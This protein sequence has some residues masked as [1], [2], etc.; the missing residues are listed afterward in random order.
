MSINTSPRFLFTRLAG[1]GVCLS[2]Y[3]A[4]F[5][6]GTSVAPLPGDAAVAVG[7]ERTDPDQPGVRGDDQTASLKRR[8]A[9]SSPNPDA[10]WTGMRV[11]RITE[12]LVVDLDQVGPFSLVGDGRTRIIMAGPGPALRIVGTHEGTA[13]PSSMKPNI[14]EKQR[15]P[16]IDNVEIVGEH[17]E[18]CGIELTG[19]VQATITR[20]NIRD[21][22]HAIHLTRRNR[23]VLIADCHLYHN[24]G[25]GLLLDDVDLHQINVTGCHISYNDG[26]GVVSRKGNVRNL[27]I[28]GCD[29]ESNHGADSEPTANV[30]IDCRDSVNGTAEV[31]ITGCT[32]QHN[33]ESP[34]SANIRIIGR[35]QDRP[36]ATTPEGTLNREGN[37][38][39]TGNVLSDVMTNVHLKDC[40]GVTLQGNT[41]WMGFEHNLLVEDC[42]SIVLGPNNLDRN[43]RYAY[44]KSLTAKNAVIF[45]NVTDSL[46]EGLHVTNVWN[47]EAGIVFDHCRWLN[48]A[49]CTVFDSDGVGILLRD[50]ENCQLAGC[51]VRDARKSVDET[52]AIQEV[53]GSGNRI[54]NGNL[55]RG[56]IE[57]NEPRE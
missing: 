16:L 9:G 25:C 42:A 27:H 40:R 39:I 18:A 29:I 1:L 38:T 30:L 56:R 11:Y 20:V 34:N 31:A 51:M 50:C 57:R 8:I 33:S 23:N 28:T 48:I 5:G 32:I 17:P 10:R 12:T 36:N 21:C 13:A 22:L 6:S 19:T 49:N 2:L 52:L 24:R 53:G 43:P 26:G 47:A 7:Q 45:R 44:G 15:T 55:T 14:W 4:V 37:V 54:A 3:W 46:I 35:S 41:F